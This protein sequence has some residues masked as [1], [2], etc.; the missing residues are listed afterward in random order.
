M[1]TSEQIKKEWHKEN[2][3]YQNPV[4]K[5]WLIIGDH[6]VIGDWVRIGDNV[7]IG[8]WVAIGD[9]VRIGDNVAIREEARIISICH[10]YIGS[11]IINQD[12][13]QIRIGCEI[14]PIAQWISHGARLAEK[15]NKLLWWEQT[16]K[17]MLDLLISEANLFIKPG[18]DSEKTIKEGG[19]MENQTITHIHENTRYKIVFERAVVKGVD[20]FKVEANGDDLEQVQL[21][22][23][24]LYDY[25]KSKTLPL[26]QVADFFEELEKLIPKEVN[27]RGELDA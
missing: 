27:K 26:T 2:G 1:I 19:I 17:H 6:V 8:D 15:H 18:R 22:T 10:N 3:W 9:E 20:G 4:T 13:V 12:D 7:R 25:A 5:T 14:H 24:K 23:T 11:L 16:G 21:E